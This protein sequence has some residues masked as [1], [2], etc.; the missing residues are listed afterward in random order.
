MNN[1][2][3]LLPL[4]SELSFALKIS[5]YTTFSM[6]GRKTTISIKGN[7][8]LLKLYSLNEQLLAPFL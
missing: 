8:S 6:S 1:L 3:Q 7:K 5:A 2:V 4:N